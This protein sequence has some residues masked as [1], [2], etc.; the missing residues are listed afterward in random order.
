MDKMAGPDDKCSSYVFPDSWNSR[1][2]MQRHALIRYLHTHIYLAGI[3]TRN[4]GLC[5]N[6]RSS[7]SVYPLHPG[8]GHSNTDGY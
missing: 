3:L 8:V 6:R 7:F 5:R 2:G 1:P 4:G